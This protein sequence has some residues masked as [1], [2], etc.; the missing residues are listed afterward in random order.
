MIKKNNIKIDY[1]ICGDGNKI[2]PRRCVKCMQVCKPA[3]FLLHQTAGVIEEDPLDPKKW[4]ITPLWPSL[5]NRCMECVKVC[6]ENAI[7]IK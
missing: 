1:L 2:D 4:R 3:I 6:P 7:V 5:C